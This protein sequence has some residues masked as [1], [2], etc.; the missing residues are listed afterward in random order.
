MK[1]KIILYDT[2]LRDGSQGEEV[3]FTVEDKL[4][5][6]RKLDEIG[7]DYIEAGWPGSNPKDL[8]FFERATELKLK[9]S[10]LV[11]FGSTGKAA[12][13]PSV[14]PNLKALLAAGTPV[15]TIFGKSWD[16]HV[17]EALKISLEKNLEIIAGSIKFLKKNKNKEVIYDAEH[18]FDGYKANP[19]YALKTL[20]AAAESGADY[21]VLC[22]TNGGS[23]PEEIG[24]I[25][26]AVKKS[27]NVPL[28]IHCHNDSELGVAN[29]LAAIAKGA[30]QVH[31]TVNGYGERCGNANLISVVA[32]LQLKMGKK[33]LSP[34]RLKKLKALSRFVAELANMQPFTHQ[35]FVG[36]SAFAHKG[37]V[38]VSAVIKNARTYEHIDPET[39]GNA[40]RVL[41][42]DLSGVSNI[43]YKAE[44][45][46][47]KIDSHD[48]VAK[49]I[50][51]HI[52][53]LE[54]QGFQFESAEASFEILIRKA[55][56]KYKSYFNLISF[57]VTDTKVPGVEHAQSEATIELEV[58]GQR[59][60][61]HF[62]G[63][64]PVNALDLCL[65]QA[66]VRFYPSIKDVTLLDY[67]VRVLPAGLGTRSMVRVLIENSDG[68]GVWNTVG[69]SENI[70]EAS[71]QALVDS[72]EYKLIKDKITPH[73]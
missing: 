17:R 31:G 8:E 36:D 54:N 25:V 53:D 66:L 34:E 13:K 37:G 7:L 69:V 5:V 64:G 68:Q 57:K 59:E 32:N 22:D 29:S 27:T 21:L 35:P 6:C 44:E 45:L 49:K 71:W 10:K 2:T 23:L 3:C 26:A 1:N 63:H 41:V 62:Q 16:F 56:G 24:E 19:Q 61:T 67:K 15:V 58:G 65:R 38:H 73:G 46:G 60:L 55:L 12:N 51:Q 11:A 9:N 18:F 33:C 20:L 39:V 70:I 14:D 48:P 50:V 72:L 52:K 43:V 4:L 40:R 30:V 42:S 28:G 47:I